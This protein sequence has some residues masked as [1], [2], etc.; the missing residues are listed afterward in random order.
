MGRGS[1]LDIVRDY[2]AARVLTPNFSALPLAYKAKES[3]ILRET[4]FDFSAD[5]SMSAK[6]GH[7]C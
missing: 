5:R 7:L 3:M 1:V 6:R 2:T 4:G